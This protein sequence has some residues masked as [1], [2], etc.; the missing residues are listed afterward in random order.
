MKIVA[1]GRPQ[2]K[3][4]A[5]M[6]RAPLTRFVRAPEPHVLA[7]SCAVTT[8]EKSMA[9]IELVPE[10]TYR[11]KADGPLPTTKG[12][13][14]GERIYWTIS[15]AEIEGPRI[16]ARLA[17]PG[18][19]WLLAGGDRFWRP[20]V[21]AA[22]ETDDGATVLMHYVG[23]V[24]QTEAFVAAAQSDTET[25]WEDQYLR[26]TMHFETGA[27]RYRWLTESLFVGRGRLLGTG[28]IE[29]AVCRVS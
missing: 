6:S 11:V 13:P 12:S 5:N 24:E 23:L 14:F 10:F 17:A 29:Y 7:V 8:P 21:R 19:D 1:I 25:R 15:E 27:A 4:L 22:L 9:G 2:S 3:P 20:D 26:V 18:S 28:R 16:R